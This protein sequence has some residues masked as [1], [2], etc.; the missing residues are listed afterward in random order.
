MKFERK[1]LSSS[2]VG[3]FAFFFTAA[4][5]LA[6]ASTSA[7]AI[8]IT[9]RDDKDHKVTVIEGETKTDHA[10]K[11]TAVIENICLKGCVVRLN[12]SEND[13]YELEGTEVVSIEDG[14]LYYDGPDAPAENMPAPAPGAPAP[15]AP[16]APAPTVPPKQPQ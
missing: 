6:V 9:N 13:E 15:A 7:S 4:A 14:Y 5:T 1:H 11:A 16:T 12:D 8:S 2:L 10:L 3:T